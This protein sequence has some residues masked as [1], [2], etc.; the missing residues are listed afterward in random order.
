MKLLRELLD[1]LRE[2]VATVGAMTLFLVRF[3]AQSDAVASAGRDSSSSRS[4]TRVRCR[5]SSS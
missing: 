3:L 4:T 1:N 2:F 5:S